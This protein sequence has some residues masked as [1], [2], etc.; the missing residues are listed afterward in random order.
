MGA[1][2]NAS[3]V[4]D[5]SHPAKQGLIQAMGVYLDTILV[6]SATAFV[7]IISGEEV[8]LNPSL[9]RLDI[10]QAALA[11]SVGPWAGHF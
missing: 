3:S 4:S 8:Y 1:V 6:C 9:E 11:S 7:I 2:P 10:T 5:V